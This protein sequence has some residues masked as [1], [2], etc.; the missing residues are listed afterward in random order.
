[1]L[2]T[3][4]ALARQAFRNH[5]DSC[6]HRT[7]LTCSSSYISMLGRLRGE[8]DKVGRVLLCDRVV[9]SSDESW[10]RGEGQYWGELISYFFQGTVSPRAPVLT[11]VNQ[12]AKKW[13]TSKALDVRLVAVLFPSNI[14][15]AANWSL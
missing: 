2:T 3:G 4:R 13:S 10:F 5:L 15:G 12:M 11:R 8:T 7:V 6:P 1:M 9:G 14:F